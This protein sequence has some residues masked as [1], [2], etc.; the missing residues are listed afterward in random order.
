MTNAN[1]AMNELIVRSARRGERSRGL[2]DRLQGATPLG[3]ERQ[4]ALN[5]QMTA[6]ET[7]ARHGDDIGAELA[8]TRIERLLNDARAARQQADQ[9]PTSSFDGGSH[10]ARTVAPPPQ[11]RGPETA[12][13]LFAAAMTASRLE[14]AERGDDVIVANT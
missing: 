3:D 13:Q 6:Y 9:P 11:M 2:I 10:G 4:R 14:R 5:E 12:G 7:A 1:A 8:D